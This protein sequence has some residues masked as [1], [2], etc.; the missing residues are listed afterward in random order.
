MEAQLLVRELVHY[1][2]P[3]PARS[4]VEVAITLGPYLALMGMMLLLLANGFW[5]GLVLT[6]P[7]GG[8]LV[9]LFLIQH[10]C[11]HGAFLPDRRSNDWLGRGLGILTLT[12]YDCWRRSHALHHASTGNLDGRGFGDVD[13]LTVR[14]FRDKGRWGQLLY[15]VYRHPIV[16]LGL[17]PAY[18]FLLRH[19]LPVGLMTAGKGYWVNAIATN[20]VTAL[21]YAVL[22]H[23]AGLA[24]FLAVQ[25]PVTLIAAS[26][27]VWLFYVQHQFEETCW[28]SKAEWSFHEAA[29]LGS[30]HLELPPILRWFTA[31]VGLHHVHH[32]CSR[33]PFYRLPEV[34]RDNPA[35]ANVNRL[36][37]KDSLATFR[38]ALW[39]EQRQRL[40]PFSSLS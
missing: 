19:R 7:A 17:G 11:G 8:L 23:A 37:I 35:L 13:T 34:L 36:S 16:I 18:L 15:R 39:D 25:L 24:A 32:L 30:S 26:A 33:V 5:A 6:L 28:T 22:I 9:R 27:G 3:R 38:L 40:V 1:R 31:N 2:S 20:A 29:L 4:A 12:P 14:E 21:L 10:D